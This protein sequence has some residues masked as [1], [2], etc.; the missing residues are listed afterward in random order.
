MREDGAFVCE[1]ARGM[2]EWVR[3]PRWALGA[4]SCSSGST[5]SLARGL[6]WSRLAEEH[7]EVVGGIFRAQPLRSSCHFQRLAS[8]GGTV[9][10]QK[11][12]FLLHRGV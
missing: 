8:P 1:R 4:L 11:R 9:V 5:P 3:G 7:L 6:T 10:C 2:G 12:V